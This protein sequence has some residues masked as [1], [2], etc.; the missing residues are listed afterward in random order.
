LIS[1]EGVNK[2]SYTAS[3]R[4]SLCQLGVVFHN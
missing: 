2:C 4:Y 1:D 3:A